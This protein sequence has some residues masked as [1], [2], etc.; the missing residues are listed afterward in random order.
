SL[1]ADRSQ[2]LGREPAEPRTPSPR[3]PRCITAP[4]RR[5]AAGALVARLLEAGGTVV[6][7]PLA[8]SGARSLHARLPRRAQAWRRR[9]QPGTH[10]AAAE[11]SRRRRGHWWRLVRPGRGA[12]LVRSHRR[13]PIARLRA[14]VA[15][16]L[17]G[18]AP[19]TDR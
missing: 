9:L 12:D 8:D 19:G 2:G 16:R 10:L 1:S 6:V 3:R 17:P 13:R 18:H 4:R 15:D 5:R 11:H 7:V 14:Q